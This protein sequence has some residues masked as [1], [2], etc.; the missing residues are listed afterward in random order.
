[1]ASPHPETAATAASATT[2]TTSPT[3]PPAAASPNGSGDGAV[4][5]KPDRAL[6]YRNRDKHNRE[7][8]EVG[9]AAPA[10]GGGSPRRG[11]SYGKG[12]KKRKNLKPIEECF[13]AFEYAAR[14][15]SELTIGV[16]AR[17]TVLA[18]KERG[19]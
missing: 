12:K 7:G 16:G 11:T 18:K 1:M 17:V 4:P 13:G 14:S 8:G 6:K 10:A 19:W 3:P 5:P 2:T 9:A 15:K